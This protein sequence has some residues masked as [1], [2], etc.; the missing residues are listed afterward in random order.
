MEVIKGRMYDYNNGR[1]LSVDP[2]IQTDIAG[3]QAINP[4][5]YIFNNP[6]SGKDPTG[7]AAEMLLTQHLESKGISRSELRNATAEVTTAIVSGVV[8]AVI[9][10]DEVS[11]YI[12]PIKGIIKNGV[13]ATVKAAVKNG[14]ELFGSKAKKTE[15]I[16]NTGSQDKVVGRSEGFSDKELVDI[17]PKTKERFDRLNKNDRSGKDFTKAGKENVKD[18]NKELNGGKMK[19]EGC[20]QDVKES[21]QSKS[22]VTPDKK[23][24][25][26][27]HIDRKRDGGS[28][29]PDN[30][31]VLCRECNIDEKG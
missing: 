27:D 8:T 13:K 25:N 28:G 12:N 31:Q 5:S 24:A 6:L 18:I 14:K 20:K 17:D 3:S 4:Y 2:F 19:C 21:T 16:S 22:G 29:T 30:G 10:A 11:D 7:Y 15:S 26:V 23:E 1:F 9:I